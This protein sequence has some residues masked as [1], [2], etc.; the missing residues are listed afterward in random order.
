MRRLAVLFVF[1]CVPGRAVAQE[2]APSPSPTLFQSDMTQ[3]TG[4]TA[5]DAMAGMDMPG[6]TFMSMGMARLVS[7]HQGGL[8]GG[9][10]VESSNWVMFMGQH[11]LGRGRLT[12]MSMSSLEAATFHKGGSPQLFQTGETF[13]GRPLVDHQHPHD[14]VMNLSATWRRRVAAGR[15]ARR[16]G[17]G[18]HHLHAPR[19]RGRKPDGDPEPP[20]PG[21]HAHHR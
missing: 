5:E 16:A 15:A 10:T 9:H 20:L 1:A 14:F 7:N 11:G 4:Q 18:A 21:L 2:P 3:M 17:A 6:W 13:E 19:V 8:S 12:L